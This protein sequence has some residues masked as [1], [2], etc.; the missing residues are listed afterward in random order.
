[1]LFISIAFWIVLL[2]A[3]AGE[4]EAF[5]VFLDKELVIL[6]AEARGCIFENAS[7]DCH[8]GCADSNRFFAFFAFAETDVV[9]IHVIANNLHFEDVFA[10][11]DFAQPGLNSGVIRPVFTL[12]CVNG[13]GHGLIV[14]EQ[15]HASLF[16]SGRHLHFD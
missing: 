15:L 14:D 4:V 2:D 3:V 13:V 9:D 10:G 5:A 16:G 1:M 7:G 8:A 6:D 12:F 11:C